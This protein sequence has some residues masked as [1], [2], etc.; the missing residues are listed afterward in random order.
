[1][2][3]TNEPTTPAPEAETGSKKR[4]GGLSTMLLADLKSMAAGMGVAG[5]GSMKKAQLIEAIKA[6]QSGG[7]A[8]AA[9]TGQPTTRAGTSSPA[10]KQRQGKQS[11]GKQSGGKQ[12][13]GKQS[14]GKQSGGKQSGSKQ[15][16]GDQP[17][18]SRRT[19]RARA[20]RAAGGTSPASEQARPEHGPGRRG[21][22]PPQPPTPGAPQPRPHGGRTEPDTQV[23]DDD[24]LVPAAGILDVLDNYAFV[25][26]S[27]YLAGAD[28]VYLSLSMVRKY[29]LRRGD[30]IVGQVRQPREGERKEKFNPMVRVDSVNGADPET[31]KHRVDF[32]QADPALPP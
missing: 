30:A 32:S 7:Q 16:K 27:G 22:Q 25:R 17:R 11:E 26:T 5:A 2:T 4:G 13:G 8:G 31:A 18:T 10:D 3:D 19:S 29:G 24:V 14:G 21:R 12:S 20:T 9:A 23:Y 1:M 6:A 28:D 15:G